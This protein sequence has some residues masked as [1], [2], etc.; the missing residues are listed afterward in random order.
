MLPNARPDA[1]GV[2]HR[3]EG[4]KI[5]DKPQFKAKRITRSYR[6]TIDA[7]PEKIFP[8]LCPVREAEWLDGWRYSMIYSHSGLVEQ[9]AVFS[10]PSE[11]EAHTVW[12]VTKHDTRTH[13]VDFARFTPESRTCTL[14]I[15]VT[16]KDEHSSYVDVAYTYTG[17]AAAGND[18]IDHFS[19]KAFLDAVT[20]W[21]ASMNHFLKTGQKLKKA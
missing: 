21:E 19:E 4:R 2:V 1:A 8:L 11:S 9:G 13:E 5:V 16:S 18:F 15:I 12:I 7:T 10:T 17:I 14:K 6:Q 20:L 3:K